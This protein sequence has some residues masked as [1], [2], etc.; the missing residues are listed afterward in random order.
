MEALVIVNHW[1]V[2][3]TGALKATVTFKGAGA[4]VIPFKVL[5]GTA[6][7]SLNFKLPAPTDKVDD[8]TTTDPLAIS[9]STLP[10]ATVDV[11]YTALLQASGGT[12]P[13]TWSIPSGTLPF[14]ISLGA[15]T[16]VI[17][18]ATKVS[19]TFNFIV[20]VTDSAGSSRPAHTALQQGRSEKRM[21]TMWVRSAYRE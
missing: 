1:P 21:C 4:Y 13:Y 7:Y 11:F 9:T 18:G 5:N 6:T 19:G 14:G 12:A 2:T 10:D 8:P 17:S 3:V 20:Q 16:G 15:D